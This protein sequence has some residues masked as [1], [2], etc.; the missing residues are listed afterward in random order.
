ME[1]PE[2]FPR[3]KAEL[4]KHWIYDLF[5]HYLLAMSHGREYLLTKEDYPDEIA[6]SND[7]HEVLNKVRY[8]TSGDL[9]ERWAGIGYKN[10]ESTR[11][12][13]L[14]NFPASGM[15]DHVPA[16]IIDRERRKMSTKAGM[17]GI[18]GDIHSHPRKLPANPYSGGPMNGS[19]SIADLYCMVHEGSD[20][21]VMGLVEGFENIFVMQ[22]KEGLK[23]LVQRYIFDQEGFNKFWYEQGGYEYISNPPQPGRVK[24]KVA[25]PK[26]A[27]EICRMVAKR[28]NLVLYHGRANENLVR[29]P[30]LQRKAA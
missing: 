2:V 1:P 8:D 22:T 29:V 6:L 23:D 25:N 12:L 3:N 9:V 21:S 20:L 19:F 24:P 11:G 17:D 16:E 30:D 7:W 5:K 27:W 14:P 4:P 28:H 15:N 10:N 26:S 13:Y 18:I